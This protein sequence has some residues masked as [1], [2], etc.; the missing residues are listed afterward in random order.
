[1]SRL[2]PLVLAALVAPLAA[3]DIRFVAFDFAVPSGRFSVMPAGGDRPSEEIE[4]GINRFSETLGLAVGSYQLLGPSGDE[5][6]RFALAEGGG[7]TLYIVLPA[8]DGKVKLVAA[9]DAPDRFGPGERMFINATAGE[10]RVMFGKRRFVLRTGSTHIGR[11]DVDPDDPRIP[12]RMFHREEQTWKMFSST[13]WP[14]D[15]ALRSIVLIHPSAGR[16]GQPRVRSLA[17]LVEQERNGG[18]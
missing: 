4:I 16:A 6:A 9:P 8:K 11:P 1:M 7:P 13:M 18:G 5:V 14:H 12:V 17:E 2:L 3:V 15:P 10:I